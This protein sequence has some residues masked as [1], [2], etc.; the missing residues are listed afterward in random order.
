MLRLCGSMVIGMTDKEV[1]RK[2]SIRI[3][4]GCGLEILPCG[5]KFQFGKN[6]THYCWSCIEEGNIK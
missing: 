6:G 5:N 3:C 4:D 2:V 1:V